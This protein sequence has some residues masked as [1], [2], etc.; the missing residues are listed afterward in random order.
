MGIYS[1]PNG[2]N[3][4]YKFDYVDKDGIRKSKSVNTHVPNKRGN[5][6]E[7]LKQGKVLEEEFLSSITANEIKHNDRRLVHREDTIE[8]YSNFW[9]EN[10]LVYL[11]EDTIY[12]YKLIV[13]KHIIPI[14]GKIKLK[15]LD[16]YDLEEFI[17][18][19]IEIC[20]K[21]KKDADKK[22]AEGKKIRTDENPYF[23]SIKKIFHCLSMIL[24][25]AVCIGAIESNP[26]KKVSKMAKKKI[27][28]SNFKGTAYTLEEH[29]KLISACKGTV[30]EPAIMLA[31]Y[32][33]LRREEVLGLKWSDIDFEKD[34][35]TI[36]NTVV[37]YG[38]KIEYRDDITKTET[39]KDILP[40]IKPLKDYLLNLKLRQEKD[41]EF[42]GDGYQHSDYICRWCDGNLIK[43]NYISQNFKKL[44]VENNMRVIRFHDLRDTVVTLVWE[45]TKDIKKAQ[46][47]ARHAH[48]NITADIY[49]DPK[50]DDKRA[51]LESAFGDQIK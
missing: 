33:A 47:I 35:V 17:E 39:S 3:Y 15:D 13:K 28:K 51:G 7:A 40:L 32:L 8:E 22:L 38:G 18:K 12:S 23:Y 44:L 1:K 34:Q 9:L 29:A 30:L 45:T 20:N 10:R 48:I 50:L 42:W 11:K 31:A 36:Q 6:K 41:A 49:T 43:P 37:T 16:Q 4:Y 25:D 5:K 21:L 26:A 46:I 19:H 14:I 24:S 2:K 27:P